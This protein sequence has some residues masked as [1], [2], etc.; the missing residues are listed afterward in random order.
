MR[1]G[2]NPL[3]E[4]KFW[5]GEP[6]RYYSPATLP[7]AVPLTEWIGMGIRHILSGRDHIAF[8]IGL[9]VAAGTLGSLLGV[10]T[11]FTLAHSI[12]LALAAL[13][14]VRAPACW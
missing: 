8:V 11:A 14:V 6:R 2:D 3:V 12:T 9:L 1:F 13:H 7:R 4:A 5:A 10:I